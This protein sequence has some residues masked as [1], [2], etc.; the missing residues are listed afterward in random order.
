MKLKSISPA[1]LESVLSKLLTAPEAVGEL[2]TAD[3]F[4]EFLTAVAQVICD[5]CGG[6][7]IKEASAT[8]YLVTVGPNDCLPDD[9]GIW[10]LLPLSCGPEQLARLATKLLTKPE[11]GGELDTTEKHATFVTDVTQ[12][13]CD[14]CGGEIVEEA[15]S[16]CDC[17]T[18]GPN[19]SLPA[20]GGVWNH[21]A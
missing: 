19:D 18:V 12:L 20:N 8:S 5:H 16:T 1:H 13:I 6:E 17:V 9:G 10:S 14:H 21:V 11:T 3:K 15:S 2:D 4:A 7:I